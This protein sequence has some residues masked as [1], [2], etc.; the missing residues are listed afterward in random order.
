MGKPSEFVTD[1]G[2]RFAV[3]HTNGKALILRESEVKAVL[4]LEKAKGKLHEKLRGFMAKKV[5]WPRIRLELQ[6]PVLIWTAV[7]GPFHTVIS[8]EKE[9][10]IVGW[11]SFPFQAADSSSLFQNV[12]CLVVCCPVQIRTC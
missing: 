11:D 9:V 3:R 1:I 10:N 12:V 4:S 2:S 5:D 8:K 7:I 6:V